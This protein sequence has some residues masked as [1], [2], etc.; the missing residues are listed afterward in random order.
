MKKSESKPIFIEGKSYEKLNQHLV[1][2]D[3]ALFALSGILIIANNKVSGA[4]L[5]LIAI[6]F[7]L[8]TKDNPFL[9]NTKSLQREQ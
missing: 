7:I 3:G 4:L 2:V 5:M 9:N 6:S 8:L 1:K